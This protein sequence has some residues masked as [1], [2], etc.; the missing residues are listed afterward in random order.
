ME[1]NKNLVETTI[2]Y[3]NILQK[4]DLEPFGD[5][6][7]DPNSKNFKELNSLKSYN[8]NLNLLNLNF[9]KNAMKFFK[10]DL[11]SILHV[12]FRLVDDKSVIKKNNLNLLSFKS[13]EH[14]YQVN[15][16]SN[17]NANEIE[18]SNDD[19]DEE[20][21]SISKGNN[22]VKQDKTSIDQLISESKR[23]INEGK[24][25]KDKS[26]RSNYNNRAK[27][28]INTAKVQ[29]EQDQ[30]NLIKSLLR[31]SKKENKVDLHGLSVSNSINCVD[32]SLKLWWD[33]ELNLREVN[34][35]SN[36]QQSNAL[37]VSS[38]I[39]ITGRGIHSGGGI[40]KIKNSVY[41]FLKD[42][43]YVF[44]DITAGFKINGKKRYL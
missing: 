24:T 29:Y 16:M 6:I 18:D 34:L 1:N 9:Y 35:K 30:S 42:S 31:I 22:N 27:E 14:D 11:D 39:I 23:L 25:Y 32:Q 8:S 38:F 21:I 40:G 5:Y 15:D 41:K 19:D 36:S 43:G 12:S 17:E 33:D 20:W 37:F 26:I 2:S 7:F 44:E 10:G 13:S 28:L 3:S 4:K